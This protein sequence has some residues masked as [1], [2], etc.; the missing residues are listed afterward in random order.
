MVLTSEGLWSNLDQDNVTVV[1]Q[2]MNVME[3]FDSDNYKKLERNFCR[4]IEILLQRKIVKNRSKMKVFRWR[5]RL[6]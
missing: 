4:R 5:L 2:D 1:I 6:S 3:W